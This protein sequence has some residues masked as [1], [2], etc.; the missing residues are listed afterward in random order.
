[1]IVDA[2]QDSA[3]PI[4]RGNRRGKPSRQANVMPIGQSTLAGFRVRLGYGRHLLQGPSRA[5]L[6]NRGLPGLEPICDHSPLAAI[7]NPYEKHARSER[8]LATAT[9]VKYLPF[10]PRFLVERFRERPVQ[11]ASWKRPTFRPLSPRHVQQPGRRSEQLT[12]CP[13]T[14][15]Q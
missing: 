15:T 1:M 4:R 5:H 8:V 14:T 6:R 10:V 9:V 12:N 2:L 3:Q 13:R 7:L 11:F